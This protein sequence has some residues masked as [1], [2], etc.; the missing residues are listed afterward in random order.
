MI[1]S[2]VSL[3]AT[4]RRWKRD[5]QLITITPTLKDDAIVDAT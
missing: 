4:R 2:L 5:R 1:A 3:R